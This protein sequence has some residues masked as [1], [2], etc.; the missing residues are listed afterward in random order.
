MPAH[1]EPSRVQPHERPVERD[2]HDLEMQNLIIA[3]D[4]CSAHGRI[5]QIEK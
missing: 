2:S 4:E 1:V 3:A 5:P